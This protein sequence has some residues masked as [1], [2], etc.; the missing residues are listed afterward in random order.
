MRYKLILI[1]TISFFLITDFIVS[2]LY[3]NK[4]P[5]AI[6]RNDAYEYGFIS[7]LNIKDTYGNKKFTLC[8]DSNS[9][10]V[11]CKNSKNSTIKENNYDLIIMGDSFA[12]GIGIDF[13][14]TFVGK[15]QIKY[16]N[17]KIGNAGVR[18]YSTKNYL[19]KVKYLIDKNFKI[20]RL[21]VFIDISDLEDKKDSLQLKSNNKARQENLISKKQRN[22][23]NNF[24]SKFKDIAKNN[25]KFTYLFYE[26]VKKIYE[27]K[28]SMKNQE[29]VENLKINIPAYNQNYKR[30]SWTY[31]TSNV[32]NSLD[33]K[34]KLTS[35]LNE[36]FLLCENNNILC[37]IAV[38]PWPNQILYGTKNSIHAK[39]WNDFC[40]NRCEKFVN[41]FPVFFEEIE[42]QS[43]IEI[44]SKYYI[45]KDVHFNKNGHAKLFDHLSYSFDYEF[46]N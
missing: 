6:E 39:L 25:L 21:I 32:L 43:P 20:K 8:T 35:D 1:N 18:G 40:I 42:N 12:E 33:L 46:K 22:I 4:N 17:L 31:D 29:F 24:F 19:E 38:Y 3:E 2:N 45:Y 10:R 9:F 27:K 37:S 26:Y 14:D 28:I 34:K 30:S 5:S 44:I 7:N 16:P 36:L 15:L 13:K 11:S 23:K 41:Y